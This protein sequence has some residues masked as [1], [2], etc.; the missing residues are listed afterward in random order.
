MVLK[1]LNFK[2][3]FQVLEKVLRF[4]KY[5]LGLKVWKF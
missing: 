1:V 3:G 5:S 4:A 2:N